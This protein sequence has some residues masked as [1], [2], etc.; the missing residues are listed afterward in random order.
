[1]PDFVNDLKDK[2]LD[3]WRRAPTVCVVAGLALL[4]LCSTCCLCGGC[5]GSYFGSGD[6]DQEESTDGEFPELDEITYR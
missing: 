2:A 5:M 1:M 4:L 3:L 6:Q